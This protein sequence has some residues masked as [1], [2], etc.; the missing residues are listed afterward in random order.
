MIFW[1]LNNPYLESALN[2]LSN[3]R[4]NGFLTFSPHYISVINSFFFL[5][6]ALFPKISENLLFDPFSVR[7]GYVLGKKPIFLTLRRRL[8]AYLTDSNSSFLICCEL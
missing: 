3:D 6:F 5:A 7:F 2:L 8:R 1:V 4:Y